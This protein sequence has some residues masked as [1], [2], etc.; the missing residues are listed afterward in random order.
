M[1]K[2]YKYSGMKLFSFL[3]AL[4]FL[5]HLQSQDTYFPPL[6]G[7]AWATT[8]PS[9]LGWCQDGIDDLYGF[10]NEKRPKPLSF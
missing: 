5:T 1:I 4:C 3:L 7:D 10:L 9:S 6:S 8:D 2:K